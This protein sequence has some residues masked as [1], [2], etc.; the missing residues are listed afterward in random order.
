VLWPLVPPRRAR[1][2]FRTRAG[3]FGRRVR[4]VERFRAIC[5]GVRRGPQVPF[6]SIPSS[7]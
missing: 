4:L 5:C 1:F 7:G 6:R 2:F 3:V